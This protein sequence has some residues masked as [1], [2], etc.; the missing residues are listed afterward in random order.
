MVNGA[1]TPLSL[2]A[3]GTLCWPEGGQRSL[4]V[5]KEVLGFVADGPNI[6]LKTAVETGV[7][8]CAYGGGGRGTLA[9]NDVVFRPS[10]EESHGLWCQKLR[11]FIDSLGD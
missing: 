11:E 5:E 10:S 6:R 3:D 7:G 2:L 4:T 8:C 9:R 1:T